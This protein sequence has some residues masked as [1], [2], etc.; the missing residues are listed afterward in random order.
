MSAD[1]ANMELLKQLQD[2]MKESG[3]GPVGAAQLLALLDPT[4]PLSAW[5]YGMPGGA[6][7]SFLERRVTSKSHTTGVDVTEMAFILLPHAGVASGKPN[8]V[9]VKY[10]SGVI[11]SMS[12][13]KFDG[14]LTNFDT[15]APLSASV[16][17]RNT[18]PT[19]KVSGSATSHILCTNGL[20]IADFSESSL[21]AVRQ[22]NVDLLDAVSFNSAALNE[23][24]KVVMATWRSSTLAREQ[25]D[26]RSDALSDAAS[27][28]Y[29]GAAESKEIDRQ[30]KYSYTGRRWDVA[31]G[32]SMSDAVREAASGF[33]TP[34]TIYSLVPGDG[35]VTADIVIWDS[36]VVT[37]ENLV[38]NDYLTGMRVK[39]FLQRVEMEMSGIALATLGRADVIV[40]GTYRAYDHADSLIKE[41]K[42]VGSASFQ[43]QINDVNS[44]KL[45]VSLPATYIHGGVGDSRPIKRLT[46]SIQFVC[47]DSTASLI[48]P[49]ALYVMLSGASVDI[50]AFS[51]GGMT[52]SRPVI[53]VTGLNAD[54]VIHVKAA[55]NLVV[56]PNDALAP[57]T[58]GMTSHDRGS[59]GYADDL[60]EIGI[61]LR[62]TWTRAGFNSFMQDFS[63]AEAS[64]ILNTPGADDEEGQAMSKLAKGAVMKAASLA[65]PVVENLAA[66]YV[67]GGKGTVKAAMK[68]GKGLFA[69]FN[70]HKKHKRKN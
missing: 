57:T 59:I 22:R 38:F 27:I 1:G 23:S 62:N 14:P 41:F 42:S 8:L 55:M 47:T 33:L 6:A 24:E 45:S 5:K 34:T 25:R 11:S 16:E 2:E 46:L 31:T 60:A 43:K 70:H 58:R 64:E 69:A 18:S 49:T 20:S 52:P 26:M 65:T 54:S 35:N 66:Q 12:V 67:P 63:V 40:V 28:Y 30:Y 7:S 68:I 29:R 36:A 9:V 56:S 50:E 32:V 13:Q 15:G 17:I 3:G 61:L 10:K 44:T 21:S 51:A 39:T 19:D 53:F 48:N 4:A 37:A